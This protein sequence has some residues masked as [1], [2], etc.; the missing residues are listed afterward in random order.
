MLRNVEKALKE[1]VEMR[2]GLELLKLSVS[3]KIKLHTFVYITARKDSVKK[4]T[5]TC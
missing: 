3:L 5:G 4:R 1:F 2:I